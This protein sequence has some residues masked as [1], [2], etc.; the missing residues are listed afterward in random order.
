MGIDLKIKKILS[1]E[2][3]K[4]Y[5]EKKGKLDATKKVELKKYKDQCE[6]N[7]TKPR[8]LHMHYIMEDHELSEHDI[9]EHENLDRCPR[10]FLEIEADTPTAK[11]FIREAMKIIATNLDDDDKDSH[12]LGCAFKLLGMIAEYDLDTHHVYVD[13]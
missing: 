2:E 7:G 8:S 6:A 12:D 13:Y 11:D 1:E 4:E 9:E 3:R 10:I 5:E